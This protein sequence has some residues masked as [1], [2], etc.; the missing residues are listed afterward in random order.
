MIL[1]IETRVEA[2]N[3]LWNRID[4]PHS[5]AKGY[6]FL[7]IYNILQSYFFINIFIYARILYDQKA[8]LKMLI[9]YINERQSR[10]YTYNFVIFNF[11]YV[12]NFEL[13]IKRT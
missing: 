7:A 11:L 8:I 13:I 9:H 6:N 10:N 4:L 2:F 3:T 12:V 1:V 5:N